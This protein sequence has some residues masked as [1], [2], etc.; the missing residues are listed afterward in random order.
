M[1]GSQFSRYRRNSS[2]ALLLKLNRGAVSVDASKVDAHPLSYWVELA[3]RGL[4]K[5]PSNVIY[6]LTFLG[7][8]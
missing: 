4:N 3:R 8:G 5:V 1:D 7:G 2:D 6:R